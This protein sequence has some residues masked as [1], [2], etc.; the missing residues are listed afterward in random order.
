MHLVDAALKGAVLPNNAAFDS[1]A[2]TGPQAIA[3]SAALLCLCGAVAGFP[4][5]CKR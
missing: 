2:P 5:T 1:M 4:L 3:C